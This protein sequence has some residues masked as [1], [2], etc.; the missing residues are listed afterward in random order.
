MK[1]LTRAAKYTSDFRPGSKAADRRDLVCAS[2]MRWAALLLEQKRPEMA[3]KTLAYCVD[4]YP[5]EGRHIPKILDKIEE[6][7]A[8]N[9]SVKF[10]VIKI[11][12]SYLAAYF[13]TESSK[14][15]KY[16]EQMIEP[17][18]KYLPTLI[19]RNWSKM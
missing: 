6:I 8:A 4:K 14:P 19:N 18:L 12:K 1:M 16:S 13:K 7:N 17:L 9:P 5:G 3:V 11:Y 2:R 15:D 10:E